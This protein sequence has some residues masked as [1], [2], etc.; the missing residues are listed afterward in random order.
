MFFADGT[1][2]P[3]SNYPRTWLAESGLKEGEA[4]SGR[5]KEQFLAWIEKHSGKAKQ[6][7]QSS[8]FSSSSVACS[9]SFF[10]FLQKTI[11]N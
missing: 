10:M 4:T 7:M 3:I 1:G 6:N 11:T 9:Y 5:W 2:E 8:E